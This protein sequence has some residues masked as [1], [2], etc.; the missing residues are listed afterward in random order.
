MRKTTRVRLVL[1]LGAC[2]ALVA[3][4]SGTSSTGGGTATEGRDLPDHFLVSV[5]GLARGSEPKAGEGC[6]SPLIDPRNGTVLNLV[7][8]KDGVGDYQVMDADYALLSRYGVDS[9]HTLR[10]DCATGKA[11]GIVGP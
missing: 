9:R 4:A 8:S 3:C 7:R 5:S 10:V 2:A 1:A 11:L 6:R